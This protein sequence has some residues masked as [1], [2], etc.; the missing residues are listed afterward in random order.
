VEQRASMLELLPPPLKRAFYLPEQH[1]ANVTFRVRD[2]GIAT[3]GPVFI[4]IQQGLREIEAA[5]SGYALNLAGSAV[6]RW[7]NLYQIVVDLTASLG[8][9][10]A[11]IFLVLMIAY[12]SI[13][14][15]LIAVIPN[16]FPLAATGA[17]LVFSG[18][19]L[20]IVSVCAFTVC[21]GIAVDDT[22]HF[23]TRYQE[24]R[25]NAPH[26]EAIRRAFTGTGTA[27]IMTTVVLVTGFTTVL[28]SDLREQRI[29]AAMG[30]L[31]IA[32]ALFGDLV[33][34]PAL[35]ARFGE[36]SKRNDIAERDEARG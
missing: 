17:F 33:F 4:R 25:L 3:Y 2:L 5:H 28:F 10:A 7:Q 26:I 14:L 21:L 34:L 12:R 18:Q 36:A 15:G 22:I 32:T 20:E 23:L 29:F 31:T 8:S 19:S 35:V 24:E 16:V 30:G 1:R 11:V 6:E 27:L 13:R 9:A